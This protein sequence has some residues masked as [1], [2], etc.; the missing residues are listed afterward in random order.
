[1][2]YGASSMPKLYQHSPAWHYAAAFIVVGI[3]HALALRAL[4]TPTEPLS[5]PTIPLR[6]LARTLQI[7]A[8]VPTPTQVSAPLPQA[9]T[10][11]EIPP[12]PAPVI[13]PKPV[14]KPTQAVATPIAKPIIKPIAKP[15]VVP[16]PRTTPV[17]KSAPTENRVQKPPA[18][19]TP[20]AEPSPVALPRESKMV[21]PPEVEVA[22]QYGAAYLQ[23]PAPG[24]PMLSRRR[25]EQGTVQL[26][27]WVTRE[28]RAEKVEV[29]K[30]S[31][32]ERLDAAAL[33]TVKQWRFIP[34][35]RGEVSV[36][37]AV[38]VPIVFGLN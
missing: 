3:L 18:S 29:V 35:R 27:V 11:V 25:R 10:P 28:G 21:A 36:A 13:A 4:W 24:Y 14:T 22:A 37:S 6:M 30:S 33:A 9:K 23:N 15:V 12:L 17:N 20:P 19:V 8:P 31:G 34:A 26:Q 16:P 5:E 1:M 2:L 7:P 32:F 38:R